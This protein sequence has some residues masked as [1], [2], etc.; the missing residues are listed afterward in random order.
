VLEAQT[1][2]GAD[3][4]TS[5]AAQHAI[6]AI[7]SAPDDPD[8]PELTGLVVDL[9]RRASVRARALGA[10]GEAVGHLRR[11]LELVTDGP[12]GPELELDLARSCHDMGHY[13]EA[14]SHARAARTAFL[15][16]GDLGREAEAASVEADA[17]LRGPADYEAAVALLEP[18]YE[19]LRRTDRR[20]PTFAVV[21]SSYQLAMTRAGRADMEL[22]AEAL[23][24]ADL[25]GDRTMVARVLGNMSFLMAR[26]D[27]PILVDLFLE[28][29]IEVAREAHDPLTV[30]VGLT[31]MSS[32]VIGADVPRALSLLDEAVESTRRLGNVE[33]I[34]L[35]HANRTLALLLAGRWDDVE[36]AA[37]Y[38]LIQPDHTAMV[39]V[40]AAIVRMARDQDPAPLLAARGEL[41]QQTGDY[42]RLGELL[43]S[44]HAREP[45]AAAQA[46]E[47]AEQAYASYGTSDDF[48]LTYA[49]ALEVAVAT[50]DRALI[51]RL[52]QIVDDATTPPRE[53]LRGHRALLGALDAARHGH[54][55]QAEG[56]FRDAIGCY[57]E[58]G[59]PVYAARGRAAYAVWL[60]GR[61]RADEAVPF[62]EA[63]RATYA[64]LGARAWLA[65]LDDQLGD[66]QGQPVGS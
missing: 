66:R 60:R 51:D 37:G 9:L 58:W 5:V 23:T 19:E 55:D 7:E 31:N 14:M 11:A 45:S 59:S 22:L 21:L 25:V 8:V 35:A 15:S 13:D 48:H 49:L 6:S 4:L 46:R 64:A 30:A 34:S 20:S 36:L 38:E 52:E 32:G 50:D 24:V 61:G 42:W 27:N 1:R 28:K 17:M 33:W 43:A 65:Q 26:A 2:D 54:E 56:L 63:A 47:A 40:L 10:P 39:V 12:A 29:S 18:Y 62:V 53:G 44:W 41:R 16:V 3:D 57:D